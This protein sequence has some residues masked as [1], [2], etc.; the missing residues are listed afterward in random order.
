MTYTSEMMKN[1]LHAELISPQEKFQ[2]L[3]TGDGHSLLFSIATD[4]N[5]YLTRDQ[6]GVSSSGWTKTDLSSALIKKDFPK[7]PDTKV[8]TFESA[9]SVQDGSIGLGMA[10]SASEGDSLF[11]SLSNSNSDISWADKMNWKAF[12]FDDT[13]NPISKLE[14]VNIF[15]CE[16]SGGTQYIYVD[17]ERDPSSAVKLVERF[18]IDPT[19]SNGQYWVKHDLA[20][21]LQIDAD[22]YSSCIGRM[23]NGHVDGLYTAGHVENSGQLIFAPVIN[24]YGEGAISPIPLDL[25]NGANSDAIASVRN[26]DLSTDLFVVSGDSLYYFASSEQK[27]GAIGILLLANPVFT[28]STKLS[29]M[30]HQGIVTIWGKNGND[31][32]Y[33]TSCK[34]I[35]LGTQ[36]AWSF[37]VPILN[38]IEEMSPF[39]NLKD[40]GN[41]IFAGGNGKLFQ[42][43]QDPTTN[44]KLWSTS[45][46]TLPVAPTSP[47]ISFNSYTTTLQIND[48][49]N[50]PLSGAKINLSASRRCDVYINGLY[51][52]LTNNTIQIESNPVGLITIIEAT[53][54]IT[55]TTFKVSIDGG[56]SVSINPMDKPFKKLADLGNENGDSSKLKSA[57]IDEGNGKTKPLVSSNSPDLSTVSSGLYN[58]GQSYQSV[59]GPSSP[60]VAAFMAIPVPMNAMSF[61]D[62]ILMAAGDLF[63]WLESGVE[64]I[65]KVVKD[66]ATAV[67][68]FVA[69]IGDKVYKAI[70]D[71]VEAVVSAAEWVF[72]AIKTAIEDIIKFLEF[73]FEWDDIKRTKEVLHNLIKLWLQN[74]VN[75][76]QSIKQKIDNGI[77]QLETDVNKWA[78]I[79]DWSG[80]GEKATKPASGSTNNP[81][82]GQNSASQQLNH[83]FQNN[84]KNI[85]VLGKEPVLDPLESI[86]K[87]LITAIEDEAKVLGEVFEELKSLAESFSKLSVEEILK[88]LIAI[89]VD[90]VL[91]SVQVVID[92]IL[93]IL[94]DLA[95][96]ALEIL[97]T[98]LHIPIISD[99][100]NAIGIPDI[101]FLDLFCWISGVAYTVVYKIAKG[102]APFPDNQYTSFLISATS[103]D[104]IKAAMTPAESLSDSSKIETGTIMLAKTEDND[105]SLI[106]LPL[107]YHDTIFITGHS[108]GALATLLSDFVTTFEAM[109]ETGDNA[110]AIPSAVLGI[111]A[112]GS[113]G[114]ANFLVPRAAIQNKIVSYSSLSFTGMRIVSKIIFSGPVQKKFGASKA[115]SFMAAEDGRATGAIVDAV[116][117]VPAFICTVWHFGELTTTPDSTDKTDAIL[118]EISNLSSYVSRIMYTIAVNDK[119]EETKAIEVGVMAIANLITAGLQTAEAIVD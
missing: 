72:N 65:V 7:D 86:I 44:S 63:R 70:L 52:V 105:G 43:T 96:T 41:T 45:E 36:T 95:Q 115:L 104:Q 9:Q 100:L 5:F 69:T 67:W 113:V 21:D 114:V 89:L 111:V 57:T 46:I 99:I 117:V 77:N 26:A 19:K 103:L 66:A 2:A 107:E 22:K 54:N 13:S 94:T 1:Y 76:I 14:I 106:K 38:G 33:Y 74:E 12:P 109:E 47:A 92:A 55:G 56:E 31:Q 53:E 110:F 68:H 35:D 32:V 29:A 82:E 39:V 58:L 79:T 83:H 116:L 71:T 30:L 28:G 6:S 112:G 62:D 73:L 3:Q 24:Y 61:G 84:A 81:N 90:G 51:Y 15:F 64:A 75:D 85:T 8:K 98:K 10:V 108:I 40:G 59:Q 48:E 78:G 4:G 17:I 11:L 119:D 88:K 34:Q 27:S 16:T 50:L 60:N 37:P 118:D 25:P 80:I 18:Y 49:N 93:N 23:P 97:D 101:S 102:K 87:D 42:I 20:I 91:S